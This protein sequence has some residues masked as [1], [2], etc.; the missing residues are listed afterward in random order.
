ELRDYMEAKEIDKTDIF[1]VTS[2]DR[3]PKAM[4]ILGQYFGLTTLPIH[5]NK[6]QDLPQPDW[7]L[8]SFSQ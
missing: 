4:E 7:D 2:Y 1:P 3:L 6:L 8:F 5:P